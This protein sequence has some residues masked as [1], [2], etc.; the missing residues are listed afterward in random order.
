MGLKIILSKCVGCGLC[1]DACPFDALVLE[2]DKAVVLSSCTL[3]GLCVESCEYKAIEM[4]EREMVKEEDIVDHR[5]VWVFIQTVDG[6]PHHVALELISEGRKL[7][8]ELDTE[9]N[10]MLLGDGIDRIIDELSCYDINRIYAVKSPILESYRTMPYV[11]SAAQ[12]ILKYK[13]EIVLIGATST[14]RDFAGGL[15]TQLRT[16]LTADCTDLGI[17]KETRSL[18]RIIR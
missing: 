6:K 14:G 7:A 13:P 10:C 9:L 5:C 15:A 11:E 12:L 2:D 18:I 3:C 8:D 4:P 16:G 1:V 17:E